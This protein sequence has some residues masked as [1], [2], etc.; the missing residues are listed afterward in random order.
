M[1]S[2]EAQM[3]LKELRKQSGAL[4]H[5][6]YGNDEEEDDNEMYV[7]DEIEEPVKS[8]RYS[9]NQNNSS[10]KRDKSHSSYT[11][12]NKI[13]DLVDS[14]HK[15]NNLYNTQTFQRESQSKDL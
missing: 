11:K 3:K 1:S 10:S 5:E 6:N 9:R 15:E 4:M 2:L 13:D 12:K 14:Y 8:N 7:Y